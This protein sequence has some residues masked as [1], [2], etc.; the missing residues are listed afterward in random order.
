MLEAQSTMA[1]SPPEPDTIPPTQESSTKDAKYFGALQFDSRANHWR[2]YYEVESNGD[3][4]HVQD[5]DHPSGNS[6]SHQ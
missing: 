3:I 5:W 2:R 6:V 1:V 4:G